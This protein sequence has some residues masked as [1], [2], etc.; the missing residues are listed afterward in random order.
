MDGFELSHSALVAAER[1]VRRAAHW[2]DSE[3]QELQRE[4]RRVV[5]PGWTGDAATSYA[6]AFELWCVGAVDVL[7]G[8]LA[9]AD[10]LAATAN[11]FRQTDEQARLELAALAD[12][13]MA[14][15]GGAVS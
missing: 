7:D 3:K 8:L 10:L 12:R 1:D 13:I 11:D 2:W 14:R 15:L 5:G 6:E 9:I 4:V